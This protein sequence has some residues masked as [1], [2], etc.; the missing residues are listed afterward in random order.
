MIDIY[1]RFFISS[2]DPE[3]AKKVQRD[4]IG[5]LTDVPG[6]IEKITGYFFKKTKELIVQESIS[7][8][9]A[10]TKTID[11]AKDVLKVAPIHWAAELVRVSSC[12]F[13]GLVT[14]DMRVL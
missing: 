5:T 1:V 14:I 9:N 8:V 10:N 13:H 6:S 12:T 11:L 2:E 3:R 4:I 7:L